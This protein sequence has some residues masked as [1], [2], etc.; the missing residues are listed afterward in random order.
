MR[1]ILDRTPTAEAHTKSKAMG[2][3][4][5]MLGHG[6]FALIDNED[7]TLADDHLWHFNQRGYAARLQHITYGKS[8]AIVYLHRSIMGD[9]KGVAYDH[10]NRDKLDC[11]RGNLRIATHG[12]NIGN[13]FRRKTESSTSQY[14][15]VSFDREKQR[16]LAQGRSNGKMVFIGR[17]K[18]EDNAAKAYNRWAE[19]YFGEFAFLNPV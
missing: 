1:K 9:T 19:S 17:F 3:S 16:F 11:R 7:A 12:Q 10:I 14:K 15:G 6:K 2:C 8:C 13:T 4:F 5:V 18:S